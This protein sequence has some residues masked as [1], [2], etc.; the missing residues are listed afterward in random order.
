MDEGADAME[1]G[2]IDTTFRDGS[3]SLWAMGMRHGMMAQIAEAMD[4]AGFEAIDIPD[5]PAFLKQ[6]IRDSQ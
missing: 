5:T 4:R 6:C 1:V 2:F 3:Q